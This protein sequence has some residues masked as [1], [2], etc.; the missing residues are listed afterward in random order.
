MYFAIHKWHLSMY[1]LVNL[2]FCKVM[3]FELTG[4]CFA[5][6]LHLTTHMPSCVV[7]GAF[8]H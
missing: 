7:P 8:I 2:K 1:F 6:K 3:V 5:K 4:N